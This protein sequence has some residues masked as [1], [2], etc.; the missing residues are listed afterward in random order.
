MLHIQ[1]VELHEF[2]EIRAPA[3]KVWELLIDWAGMM[4]WSL[5]ARSGGSLGKLVKC[6]LIGEAS[7]LPRTRRMTLDSGLAVDEE[8]FYQNDQARRI[9]YRKDDTLGTSGYIASSY[10]D[11]VDDRTC[12]LHISSWFD[13]GSGVDASAAAARFRAIYK[14]IFAGFNAYFEDGERRREIT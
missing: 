7:Q 6:E 5:S 3:Q 13:V 9:Y 1:R 2:E 8:L 10:V 11:E 14:G 4:R 12:R